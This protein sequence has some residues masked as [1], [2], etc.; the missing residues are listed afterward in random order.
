MLILVGIALDVSFQPR[1]L[2]DNTRFH[3]PTHNEE[4]WY[5]RYPYAMTLPLSHFVVVTKAIR[6]RPCSPRPLPLTRDNA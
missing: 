2:T 1:R 6:I 4:D 5:G 3:L